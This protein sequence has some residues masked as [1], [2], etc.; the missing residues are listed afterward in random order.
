M[1]Q[2]SENV[3][4]TKRWQETSTWLCG[5]GRA[6][7]GS[8]RVN[9]RLHMGPWEILPLGDQDIVQSVSNSHVGLLCS[10]ESVTA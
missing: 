1:M 6:W 2:L 10:L 8:M 3:A 7:T 9:K 5:R 4:V